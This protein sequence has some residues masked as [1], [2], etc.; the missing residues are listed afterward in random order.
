MDERW[1]ELHKNSVPSLVSLKDK[2]R[3]IN[4]KKLIKPMLRTTPNNKTIS[5]FGF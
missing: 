1:Q 5:E 4:D 3:I 2:N